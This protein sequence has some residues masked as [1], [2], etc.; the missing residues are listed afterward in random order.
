[1]FLNIFLLLSSCGGGTSRTSNI[2]NLNWNK[3]ALPCV[4]LADGGYI[5]YSGTSSGN[6]IKPSSY[7]KTKISSSEL[8]NKEK[9]SYTL[10]ARK[11]YNFFK[12][13]SYCNQKESEP[14]IL[15]NIYV[16]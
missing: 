16:E 9:P 15:T 6:F 10:K 12:V 11:G 1:M 13:S 7:I 3:V 8:D 4:N 2:I 14:S 5:I